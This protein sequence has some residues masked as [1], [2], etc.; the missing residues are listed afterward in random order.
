MGVTFKDKSIDINIYLTVSIGRPN[1]V[2][3]RSHV[4]KP[5][6]LVTSQLEHSLE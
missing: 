3:N 5:A 2:Y 4:M 6:W 1:F